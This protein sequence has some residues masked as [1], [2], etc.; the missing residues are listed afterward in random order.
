MEQSFIYL[1]IHNP[2]PSLSTQFLHAPVQLISQ[3]NSGLKKYCTGDIP[4]LG[5]PKLRLR[6]KE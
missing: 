1:Y 3:S 2:F 5:P 4:P 6:I